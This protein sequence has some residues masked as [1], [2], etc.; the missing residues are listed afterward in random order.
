MSGKQVRATRWAAV[1]A[2]AWSIRASAADY[3]VDGVDGRDGATGAAGDPLRQ[4]ASL[5]GR[6]QGGDTVYLASGTYDQPVR[7]TGRGTADAP[8]LIRNAEGH[9][10]VIHDTTWELA[11]AAHVVVEGLT[12]RRCP[13]PAF[14]F[15]EKTCDSVLRR[16]RLLECPP[17]AASNLTERTAWLRAISAPGPNAHRNRIED[18]EIRRPYGGYYAVN[19]GL[20]IHEA[21]HHWI[22]RGNRFSGYMYGLQLGVGAQGD[23][24]AYITIESNE[25]SECNHAV[26]VKTSDNIVR[27]NHVHDM[28]QGYRGYGTGIYLRGGSR[29]VVENNRIE[30]AEWA[31]VRINGTDHLVRNNVIIHTAVGVWLSSHS[32]GGAGP[33]NWIVHNTI[34]GSV[35]PIWLEGAA[36]AHVFNNILAAGARRGAGIYVDGRGMTNPAADW[37]PAMYKRMAGDQPASARLV[38]ADY[39]LFFNATP[40]SFEWLF[41]EYP[42]WHRHYRTYGGQNL[43]ADPHFVDRE[44]GDFRLRPYSPARAAGR[45]LPNCPADLAGIARPPFSPDLGAYQG[46]VGATP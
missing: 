40:P 14:V 21:N 2:V 9:D 22:V 41:E 28:R 30:R 23:P 26:H 10:P 39:N 1:F 31:G 19:E 34:A 11:G 7:L 44:G 35:V 38:G 13:S 27:G 16:C 24:P 5:A 29:T 42:K 17:P 25:F 6:L 37:N 3:H 43:E 46:G 18:C 4:I 36:N 15:G 33:G 8:I 32:Y 45:P 20:N 12:F